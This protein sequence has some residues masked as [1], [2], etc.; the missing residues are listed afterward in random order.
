MHEAF[1][2]ALERW[3]RVSEHENPRAWVIRVALNYHQSSWRVWQREAPEPPEIAVEDELPIDPWLLRTVWRL[4]MR[5]RQV[6]ALRI[7]A[8]SQRRTDRGDA[9]YH[10]RGCGRSPA[11][12]TRNAADPPGRDGVRGGDRMNDDQLASRTSSGPSGGIGWRPRSIEELAVSAGPR[13]V[14]ARMRPRAPT[15]G[16][17]SDAR[18]PFDRRRRGSGGRRVC[19]HVRYRAR[20]AANRS[21]PGPAGSRSQRSRTRRCVPGGYRCHTAHGSNAD[22]VRTVATLP[23]VVR[24]SVARSPCSSSATGRK[25]LRAASCGPTGTVATTRSAASMSCFA[26][27]SYGASSN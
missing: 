21:R 25:Y 3:D 22:T 24:T 10:G 26:A 5:Q 2:R 4:P 19:L 7:L 14:L 27:S 13:A 23:L 1:A 18:R 9:W 8:R 20:A 17:A 16:P 15:P 12:S 11:S 6:V